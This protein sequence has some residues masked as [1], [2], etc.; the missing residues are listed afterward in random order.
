VESRF[1]VEVEGAGQASVLRTA[2]ASAPRL[3]FIYAP[4]AGS[5]LGDAFGGYCASRLPDEGIECWRLQFP[6]MEARRRAPDR[7]PVLEATWRAVIEETS[8]SGVPVV[9]GGRSM[10]GRIA[11]QVVAQGTAVSGLALF[12]Y[13]L[14]PPGKPEQRRVAHLAAIDVP[15]L[16]CSGTRDAFASPDELAE[17]AALIK[18]S[19][20]HL[21][22]GADHGFA[23]LKSSGRSREDIWAEA[24]ESCL[25]FLDERVLT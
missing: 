2:P 20:V 24:V 13:P 25:A 8:A 18:G 6:Y 16:F 5:N 15:T 14:H 11:S 17:A 22:E 10:G 9:A 7:T 19:T 23:T 1:K 4:G 21:L 3:L 12:A